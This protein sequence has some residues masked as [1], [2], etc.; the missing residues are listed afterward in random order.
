VRA[1]RAVMET[2]PH[3]MLAG[4]GAA[5]FAAAAGLERVG[6]EWFTP[7]GREVRL[8]GGKGTGTVGCVALDET[9]ALAAA[10]STGGTHGKLFGRVGDSPL[11]GAGV[12][13][14]E[15]VAVSCTG[16]GEYFIRA[17]AAAQ[18]SF[19]LALAGQTLAESAVA[20]LAAVGALGGSGGL[21]AL[22]AEGEIVMPFTTAGMKRACLRPDG[23]IETA[24]F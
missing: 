12:W 16:A 17:A 13:A 18:L 8:G 4:E 22:S 1:A 6:P 15:R 7:A 23:A 9:G 5:A 19:R 20:T 2:T 11:V 24:V 10:T 3:V 14:D 21:I